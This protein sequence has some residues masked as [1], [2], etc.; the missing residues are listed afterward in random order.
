MAD[1]K[2]QQKQQEQNDPKEI[3]K[4]WNEMQSDSTVQTR[5]TNNNLKL[6]FQVQ[7]AHGSPTGIISGFNNILQ[8]YQVL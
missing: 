8:L 1:E 2:S 5:I 4:S 3:T 6:T 7:L